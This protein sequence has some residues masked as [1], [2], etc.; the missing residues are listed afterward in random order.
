MKSLDQLKAENTPV[1][2]YGTHY[3]NLETGVMPLIA[4]NVTINGT[5]DCIHSIT[6]G[7]DVFT[8][9]DVM[10]LTGVHDYYRFGEARKA[11]EIGKGIYIERGVWLA[12]RCI[13]LAGVHIGEY[14]VVGAGAVVTKDVPPYAVV[15]GNPAKV[16]KYLDH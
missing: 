16:I 2:T 7:P 1:G 8:G 10:I 6:I 9:H 11:G 14:A 15:A 4:D 5:L 3:L 12:S 13:I